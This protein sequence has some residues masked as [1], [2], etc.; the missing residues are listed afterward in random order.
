[1]NI[2][3]IIHLDAGLTNP[4]ENNFALANLKKGIARKLGTPPKQM[5]P[6]T[7]QMLMVVYSHLSMLQPKDVTFWAA[8][9]IGFLGFL[10]KITLLPVSSSNPGDAC[11]L[12]GDVQMVGCQQFII[13][14]R[15]TKTIQ[16][17][18]RVLSLPFVQCK[19]SPLCP[20]T[21]LR[22]L[23]HVSP[24][25]KKLPLFSYRVR[26]VTS[27]LTHETFT[28]RLRDLL[29][30]S[31]YEPGVYS[32]HSFRR[33]GAT[34]AFKIGMTM[35]EIKRRGD[36]R[37]NAVY[38]YIKVDKEQ[39]RQIAARLVNGAAVVMQKNDELLNSM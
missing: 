26:G 6:L 32:C 5:Q 15:R 33:G 19:G 38:E 8:C 12:F 28:S 36:W 27:W 24:K 13:H 17:R 31:G 2:I 30:M 25:D 3:R 9:C 21:A 10:R 35:D 16:C 18:E 7:C 23:L 39:D 20:V 14:V 11:I 37:S 4:L 34:L 1:M 29:K 22:N